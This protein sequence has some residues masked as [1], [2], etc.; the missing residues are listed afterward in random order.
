M[1]GPYVRAYLYGSLLP[2][3][4]R[5]VAGCPSAGPQSNAYYRRMSRRAG[6][7]IIVNEAYCSRK[8]LRLPRDLETFLGAGG[9][10]FRIAYRGKYGLGA[11][12]RATPPSAIC[13]AG[14]G[15]WPQKES[16]FDP[17]GARK[18]L[19]MLTR[20]ESGGYQKLI[21]PIMNFFY[22]C[23]VNEDVKSRIC[24]RHQMIGKQLR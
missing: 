24:R 3:S 12:S 21:N 15:G 2:L 18:A 6:I 20:L 17:N 22:I 4:K 1:K 14:K 13:C 9:S 10:S 7:P 23:V 8:A 19:M 5:V 11:P 16:G